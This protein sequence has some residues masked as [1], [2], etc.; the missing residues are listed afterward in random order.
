MTC[1]NFIYDEDKDNFYVLV[2]ELGKGACSHVFYALEFEEFFSKMKNKK[3]LKINPRA[4]KIHNENS[5][6]EG[7]EETKIEKIFV[8]KKKKSPHI[9]YPLGHF[10]HKKKHVIVIY[11][12]A[13]GSLYDVMKMFDKKLPIEF[14]QEII[15]QLISPIKLVHRCGYIYADVKP[16]NYLLMGLSNLQSS[17][18]DW[19]NKYELGEKLRKISNLKKFKTNDINEKTTY[20]P[21]YKFLKSLSKKFNLSGNILGNENDENDDGDKN[22]E[23]DKDNNDNKNNNDNDDGI[24]DAK[25][26]FDSNNNYNTDDVNKVVSTKSFYSNISDDENESDYDEVSSY[27]SRDDEYD[28]YVDNFHKKKIVEILFRCNLQKNKLNN[29]INT[30][31][32]IKEY[33]T[34]LLKNP[35][36]KLTDFGM[37]FF[38]SSEQKT[39]QTR[40]YRAP[41]VILGLNF[42]EK[43]DL[44]SL[45]CTIY[46][47]ATG[48]ILF[49]TCKNDDVKKYDVDLVHIKMIC[50]KLSN[51]EKKNLLNLILKSN[52]KKYIMNKNKC[53]NYFSSLNT[54]NIES[55]FKNISFQND[56]N[57]LD[58]LLF[59][60]L[61]LIKVEPSDRNFYLYG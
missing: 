30:Q 9:N 28:S 13:V 58:D 56:V 26:K 29:K 44:W 57:K 54:K 6:D 16:E 1:Q 32:K 2:Y 52:R 60:I 5:Y 55:E 47:L 22:D 34:H 15:P 37:M 10:I 3:E 21:L 23:N 41:E 20:E 35:K 4:L 48:V 40:Y 45:G 38:K 59:L 61:N 49:Y 27:D 7:I 18:L 14:V 19:A 39:L 46:E 8:E 42:N 50:E 51:D 12:V 24:I 17:I 25:L 36:I 11:E 31:Q 33:P 53:L 43:I